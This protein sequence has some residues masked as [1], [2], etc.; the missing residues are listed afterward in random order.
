MA[1]DTKKDSAVTKMLTE[2]NTDKATTA[3]PFA[4]DTK[5]KPVEKTVPVLPAVIAGEKPKTAEELAA[6]VKADKASG[7]DKLDAGDKVP[8][9]PKDAKDIQ[10]LPEGNPVTEVLDEVSWR[11]RELAAARTVLGT[12]VKD[13]G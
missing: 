2:A 1:K 3:N 6:E 8:A 10:K 13:I 9:S 5:A 7:N 11:Q 4:E 12:R